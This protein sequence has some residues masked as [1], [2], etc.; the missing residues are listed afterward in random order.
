MKTYAFEAE[1]E[2]EEDNHWSATIPLGDKAE[3]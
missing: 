2:K 1:L 3:K